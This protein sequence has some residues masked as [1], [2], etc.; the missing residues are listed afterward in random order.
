M[1][2]RRRPVSSERGAR[3]GRARARFASTPAPLWPAAASPAAPSPPAA[4]R[5][6][7]PPAAHRARKMGEQ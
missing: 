1:S 5:A 6:S 2:R 4:S 3:G 7:R